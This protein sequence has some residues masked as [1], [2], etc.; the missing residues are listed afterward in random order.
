MHIYV[1]CVEVQLDGAPSMPQ[2]HPGAGLAW[3]QGVDS[4][5][6]YK[7][8]I[9]KGGPDLV[10]HYLGGESPCVLSFIVFK[11]LATHAADSKPE[12]SQAE[13]LEW[14]P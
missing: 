13:H 3:V 7:H 10:S 12:K 11:S 5:E 8:R 1:G 6:E 14:Q 4:A 9:L 2:A